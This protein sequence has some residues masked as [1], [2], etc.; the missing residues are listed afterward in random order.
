MEEKV[1]DIDTILTS[2]PDDNAH[3]LRELLTLLREISTHSETNCMGA[4]NLATVIGPALMWP[5]P[6]TSGSL[7]ESSLIQLQD[8]N[9]VIKIVEVMINNEASFASLVRPVR[10]LPAESIVPDVDAEDSADS[11]D[12]GLLRRLKRMSRSFHESPS[13]GSEKR[14]KHSGEEDIGTEEWEKELDGD[15]NRVV[16][17]SYREAILRSLQEKRFSLPV[18]HSLLAELAKVP[19]SSHV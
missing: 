19:V 18:G 1:A 17:D 8:I 13:R 15:E 14:R 9:G 3:L 6:A 2:L 5:P 12:K 11:T 16:D 10:P 7:T 4:H